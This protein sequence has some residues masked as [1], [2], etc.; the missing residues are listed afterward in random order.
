[1]PSLKVGE[2]REVSVLGTVLVISTHDSITTVETTLQ[3]IVIRFYSSA[4]LVPDTQNEEVNTEV[5]PG[6]TTEKISNNEIDFA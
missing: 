2:G 5:Y 4:Y 6:R 3:L 1:M